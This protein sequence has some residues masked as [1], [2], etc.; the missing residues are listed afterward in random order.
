MDLKGRDR[1]TVLWKKYFGETE[2]PL[3]GY[4]SS[5]DGGVK[6]VSKPSGHSCLIAQLMA[7]R[8]GQPLCFR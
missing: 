8:K 4:Y 2:L 5:S 1:F 3:A 6:L 7:A